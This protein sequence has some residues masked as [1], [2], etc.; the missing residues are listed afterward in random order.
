MNRIGLCIVYLIVLNVLIVIGIVLI[1]YCD[2]V[3]LGLLCSCRI[4][5][6]WSFKLSRRND[7]NV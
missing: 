2:L 1:V 7:K 4:K 6:Q 3:L 5:L